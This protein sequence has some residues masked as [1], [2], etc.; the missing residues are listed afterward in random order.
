MV[1]QQR[2]KELIHY[3]PE[4]GVFRWRIKPCDRIAAGAIASNIS[5]THGYVRI[6]IDCR[7]YQAHRLAWLYMTGSCPTESIDH[8]NGNRT[9]NRFANLRAATATIN[10]QNQ[11]RARSDSK[12][13]MLGVSPNPGGPPGRKFAAFIRYEGRVRNLGNF[14]TATE[15]HE[16]YVAAKR[17][18][19]PGGTL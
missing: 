9:D 18:H 6:G 5:K 14:A 12:I 15:A 11:R 3:D 4:T 7:R 16:A 10:N 1:T 17:K 13:G 2:L 8:K 19:H